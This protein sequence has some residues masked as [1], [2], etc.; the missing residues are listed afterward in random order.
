MVFEGGG[1][2]G[3]GEGADLAR[4]EYLRESEQVGV[5]PNKSRRT[6]SQIKDSSDRRNVKLLLAIS[7]SS[8]YMPVWF[9]VYQVTDGFPV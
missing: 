9:Q 3:G 7:F 4:P 2:G 5:N 1:G 8:R 6:F